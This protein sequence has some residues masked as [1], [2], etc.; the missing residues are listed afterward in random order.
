MAGAAEKGRPVRQ[1]R[2]FG[3]RADGKLLYLQEGLGPNSEMQLQTSALL[4]M[5]WPELTAQPETLHLWA[6]LRRKR[7]LEPGVLLF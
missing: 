1:A 4:P 6:F 7:K 3:V 2:R 5:E